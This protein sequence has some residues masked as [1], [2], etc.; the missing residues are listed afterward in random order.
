M[1][2]ISV[3]LILFCYTGGAVAQSTDSAR[4]AGVNRKG[5][6]QAIIGSTVLYG[7]ALAGLHQLWYKNSQR[8]SFRFFNDNREWKQVDKIGHFYSSFYLSYGI[9]RGLQHYSVDERKADLI[10]SISGFAVLIPIEIF[11]GFS[12]AYGASSGDLIADAAGSFLYLSQKYLWNEVR[13]YPRFSFH[14]TRYPALR[15]ELLGEGI[16][17][18]IKDYNGQTYWLTFDM[19]KFIRFPKWLDVSVGYGAEGMIY[20]RDYQHAEVGFNEPYRQY[21]LSLDLDFSSVKTRSKAVKTLFFFA[22]MIKVPFPAVEFSSRG[23]RAH[24]LYF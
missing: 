6:N 22:R 7:G 1:R 24:A 4:E 3:L 19:D 5:L 9:S 17:Q 11:D 8:Q 14:T 15:P 2:S 13:I 16:E 12:T 20:A 10:G 21:Y 23:V 18:L